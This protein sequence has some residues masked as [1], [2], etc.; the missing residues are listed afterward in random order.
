MM[1]LVNLIKLRGNEK[2]ESTF[3]I[4]GVFVCPARATGGCGNATVTDPDRW[5]WKFQGPRRE[6]ITENYRNHPMAE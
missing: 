5:R 1:R 2:P 6:R 3:V 4:V